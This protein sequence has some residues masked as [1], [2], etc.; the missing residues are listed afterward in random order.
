MDTLVCKDE[1]YAIIGACMK[2]HNALGQGFMESVYGDA[3]E[4]E[5]KKRGIPYERE[6]QYQVTYDGE[7]LKH[8]FQPDFVCYGRVVVELKA[9]K[10]LDDGN[11]EQCCRNRA[12][13]W[14]CSYKIGLV[15]GCICSSTY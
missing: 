8:I 11:R 7:V 2:V 9:V 3:L 12:E 1:S 14:D 4:H 10:E 15:P 13:K 5:F 6:P